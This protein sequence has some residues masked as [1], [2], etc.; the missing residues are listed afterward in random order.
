[1]TTYRDKL[2]MEGPRDDGREF[3]NILAEFRKD[4][5]STIQGIIARGNAIGQRSAGLP[6]SRL[7]LGPS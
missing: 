4:F 3:S 2:M 7:R 5:R 1:M 6:F